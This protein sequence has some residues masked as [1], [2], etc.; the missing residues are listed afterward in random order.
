MLGL[1]HRVNSKYD[2]IVVNINC[3]HNGEFGNMNHMY[4]GSSD[5]VD[6]KHDR[7]IW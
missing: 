4:D 1:F 2:G 7:N 5:S 3:K 6:C